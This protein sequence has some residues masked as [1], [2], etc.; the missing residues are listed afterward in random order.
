MTTEPHDRHEMEQAVPQHRHDKEFWEGLKKHK[1]LLWRARSAAAYWPK[2]YCI[3][4]DNEP[5]PRN[6]V[7]AGKRTGQDLR[8]EPA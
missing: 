5:S 8:L 4:H 7:A 2:S 1:L 6:G 3:N